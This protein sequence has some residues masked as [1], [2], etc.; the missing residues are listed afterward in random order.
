MRSHMNEKRFW[1]IPIFLLLALIVLPLQVPAADT[2]PATNVVNYPFSSVT[3]AITAYIAAESW[4]ARPADHFPVSLTGSS[5][6]TNATAAAGMRYRVCGCWPGP[7]CYEI[8]ATP[9][10]SGTARLEVRPL[11]DQLS[12]RQPRPEVASWIRSGILAQLLKQP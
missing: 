12:P 10:T 2:P 7:S 6:F 8:E 11:T 1:E 3:N 4:P 9:V 5:S